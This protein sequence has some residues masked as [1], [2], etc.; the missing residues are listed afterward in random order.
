MAGRSRSREEIQEWAREHD[1]PMV[2]DRVQF[3]DFRIEY[4]R[5]DGRRDV[6]NVEVTTVHY[7]GA[8]A[9]GKVAGGLHAIPR[10]VGPRRRL[11]GER[12]RARPFDP[13]VAEELLG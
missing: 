6:E 5:P 8:H 9:A 13:H 12:R 3:P 1:L 4:E 11:R 10:I 2:N 7:R